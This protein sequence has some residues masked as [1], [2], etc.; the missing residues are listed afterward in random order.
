MTHTAQFGSIISGTLRPEDTIPAFCDEL[1]SLRGAIPKALW[2]DV[3]KA[4]ADQSYMD[5]NGTKL[6]NE[7][8]DE[9]NEFAPPYGYF[10]AHPGDASDFGFWPIEDLEQIAEENGAL[11]VADISE[12]PE[13][14]S[15]EVFHV[16]D[17]GNVTLYAAKTGQLQEVWSIV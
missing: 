4:Y 3:R 12:V 16:N 7:L 9:L 6:A 11:R 5:D 8:I 1:R 14:Y 10:G 2:T 17:H 15:G 13:D